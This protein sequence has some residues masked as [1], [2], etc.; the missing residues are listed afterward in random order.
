VLSHSAVEIHP[1]G[2]DQR[3][4]RFYRELYLILVVRLGDLWWVRH[5]EDEG[6]GPGA[7]EWDK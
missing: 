3:V 5:W 7:D 4:Q 1:L 2:S 6:V